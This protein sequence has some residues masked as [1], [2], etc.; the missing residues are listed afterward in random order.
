MY[1]IFA[2][3]LH[4]MQLLLT[5]PDVCHLC[6]RFMSMHYQYVLHTESF[7]IHCIGLDTL[8]YHFGV[9]CMPPA[10]HFISVRARERDIQPFKASRAPVEH[11]FHFFKHK[12]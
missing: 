9:D 10:R 6:V 5:F 8:S 11:Q 3:P 2:S 7:T 4:L 12:G 1:V